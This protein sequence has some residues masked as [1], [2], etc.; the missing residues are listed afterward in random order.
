M[1][2]HDTF[3]ERGSG[4]T[5]PPTNSLS[6]RTLSSA[7]RDLF[8]LSKPRITTMVLFTVALGIWMAPGSLAPWQTV[9]LLLATGGLVASANILNCW[10]E[11]ESDALMRRTRNRPLPAGK[12]DPRVALVAGWLLGAGS[13]AALLWTTNGLT[14][15]LGAV[16][17]VTYVLVYT[18]L[19]RV[20]WLAVVVGAVPGALPP[21]MGWTAVTGSMSRPGWVLFGILFFWQLPHFIAIA[22]YL[23]EDYRRGGLQVLPLAHGDAIARRH[24]FGYTLLLV[25]V[26][27][28]AVP[29][30]M[31]G[32]AYTVT[33]A[34][35]GAGFL[36]FAVR[37]LRTAVEGVWARRTFVYSL[38]YLCLLIGV[39]VLDAR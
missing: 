8:S 13:V 2:T 28:L 38:V 1:T 22:L 34:L 4:R 10:V 14:A 23:K 26:S 6:T 29:L 18:P 20:T 35:L 7:L 36:Y 39:L 33:A 37:G 31:A 25:V 19:K 5:S 27:L 11:R 12:L 17:L 16:A 32:P 9:L 24:L 30:E 21:L 3:A 15:V